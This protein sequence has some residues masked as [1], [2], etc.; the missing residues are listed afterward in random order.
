[1][2]QINGGQ[3]AITN[4]SF[5]YN[6][7]GNSQG[8]AVSNA[9]AAL[10]IAATTF[11]GN[12]A[13]RGGGIYQDAGSLS[14]TNVQM[15]QNTAE[16]IGGA[17]YLSDALLTVFNS[18]FSG[19]VASKPYSD[20]QSRFGALVCDGPNTSRQQAQKSHI[21]STSFCPAPTPERLAM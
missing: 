18:T 21:I 8:G 2:V 6:V 11:I 7:N 1:M 10:G 20:V 12:R 16:S 14:L 13:S 4:S 9:A 15:D 3:V 17:A 19:N 5:V